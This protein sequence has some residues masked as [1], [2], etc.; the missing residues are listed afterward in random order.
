MDKDVYQN[1]HVLD[2]KC[3]F[4]PIHNFIPQTSINDSR[5]IIP[6]EDPGASPL[7]TGTDDQS[8]GGVRADEF[9]F[10]SNDPN[11]FANF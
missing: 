3:S 9:G 10:D 8:Q 2:V 6:L 5:F 4:T 11:D 1:P 7:Q